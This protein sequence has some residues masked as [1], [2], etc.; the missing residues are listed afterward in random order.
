M[1]NAV[2]RIMNPPVVDSKIM[3][4]VSILGLCF[5]LIMM[6]ILHSSPIH[7]HSHEDHNHDKEEIDS[8]DNH[9]GHNNHSPSKHDHKHEHKEVANENINVKA[10]FIHIIGILF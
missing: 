1:V 4:I 8:H 9:T 5:N 2:Y 6:K 7:S 10:A 3:F